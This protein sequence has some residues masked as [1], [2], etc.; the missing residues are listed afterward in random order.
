[1]HDRLRLTIHIIL[2][3]GIFFLIKVTISYTALSSFSVMLVDAEVAHDDTVDVY[4]ASLER[5]GFR[6]K[7]RKRSEPFAAKVRSTQ[8]V[9]LHN[10]VVRK[11][12]LDTGSNPG[13]VKLYAIRLESNFGPGTEFTPQRIHEN[14][15]PNAGVTTFRLQN[16][17]VLIVS[18][19]D[20]PY[21]IYSGE[22]VQ[23][24]FFLELVLPL[25]FAILFFLACRNVSFK[26]VYA[27]QDMY[28][29]RSSSGIHIGSLDGVR[30]VAAL[31]VLAQHTGLTITG[32][33]YGVWLFFCLSGFLL[34]IPFVR[35]PGLSVSG[36][37]MSHYI[38]RRLKRI[39]PMYYVMITIFFLFK[40]NIATAIRHYLFLQGDGHFWTIPQE[41]FFYLLLPP[42][43][44]GSYLFC[45]NRRFLHLIF[46]GICALAAHRYLTKDL[47]VLYGHN[48]GLRPMASIFLMGVMAA[49]AHHLIVQ[50]QATVFKLPIVATLCSLCG[51]LILAACLF[52]S[53]NPIEGFE[54]YNPLNR[55]GL[56]GIGAML[57]IVT[58][59]L[60]GS[61][62]LN[63]LMS[64]LPLKAVGI[65]GYSFYLL[66]PII[67]D[68]LR[69]LVD[70]FANYRVGGVMLFVL[71]GVATYLVSIFTYS[72]IERPFIKK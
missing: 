38:L 34:S 35:Q 53:G 64:L 58:T 60:S 47:V 50:R 12:R 9:F 51:L 65:V 63:R 49:F 11:L 52:M 72:Y 4:F 6:E 8:K 17:H 61:S 40:G 23:R 30:G 32:G 14:F 1:M 36:S 37:Y 18:N 3:I 44:L 45:R 55:P 24:G 28:A 59:L 25:I 29:T 67:L 68:S 15:T 56:F 10:H 2:T 22:L 46:I 71:G 42:V 33:I 5:A 27:F 19:S 16:D 41:M 13:A 69:S 31:L 54:S 39:V 70:Y 7:Y 43:M 62:F 57:L 48:V 26:G 66:H 20:D 21:I